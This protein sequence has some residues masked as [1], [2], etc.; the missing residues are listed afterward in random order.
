MGSANGNLLVERK[1]LEKREIDNL[2][3]AKA[4]L[5]KARVE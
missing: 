3:L 4:A 1:Q 2:R 5:K